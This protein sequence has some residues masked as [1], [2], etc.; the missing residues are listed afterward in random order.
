MIMKEFYYSIRQWNTPRRY[1][2]TVSCIGAIVFC[3]WRGAYLPLEQDIAITKDRIAAAQIRQTKENT[4]LLQVRDLE[5]TI[6]QTEQDIKKIT[7][8]AYEVI[9]ELINAIDAAQITVVRHSLSTNN[10]QRM[11]TITLHVRGHFR[12]ILQFTHRYPYGLPL[13]LESIEFVHHNGE[14]IDGVYVLTFFSADL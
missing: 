8:H 13:Q 5:V 9:D 1:A 11:A 7:V 14:E 4:D 12:K 10:A 6:K 3:W 2:F